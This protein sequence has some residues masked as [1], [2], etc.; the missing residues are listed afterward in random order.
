MRICVLARS[1]DRQLLVLCPTSKTLVM[2]VGEISCIRDSSCAYVSSHRIFCRSG[3]NA[4]QSLFANNSDQVQVAIE[5]GTGYDLDDEIEELRSSVGR[6]KQV[7]TA[8]S[9]ESR[10]TSQVLETLENAMETAQLTLKVTMKR[11]NRAYRRSKSNH[12]VYLLLF[13]LA[14]FFAVYIWNRI[15]SF[16]S[17]VFGR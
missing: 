14:L 6:L 17:W 2:L 5:A 11:L 13:A 15:Y 4:R 10:L 8:I 3:L 12:M 9:E 7:S 16:L 1:I